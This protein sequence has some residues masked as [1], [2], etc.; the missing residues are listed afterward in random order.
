MDFLITEEVTSLTV[1]KEALQVQICINVEKSLQ[2]PYIPTEKLTEQARN[3]SSSVF[4]Y[5]L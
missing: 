4:R 3:P 1:T 2:S 5:P